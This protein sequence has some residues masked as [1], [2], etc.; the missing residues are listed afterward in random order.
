MPGREKK[1]I[2]LHLFT[3]FHPGVNSGLVS[4]VHL[5]PLTEVSNRARE[6]NWICTDS[7]AYTSPGTTVGPASPLFSARSPPMSNYAFSPS[8]GSIVGDS[9]LPALQGY[10]RN[11]SYMSGRGIEPARIQELETQLNSQKFARHELLTGSALPTMAMPELNR[12]GELSGTRL[13]RISISCEPAKS[14]DPPRTR[15]RISTTRKPNRS[16]EFTNEPPRTPVTRSRES[17]IDK[18]LPKTPPRTPP[19]VVVGSPEDVA[20]SSFRD[21]LGDT[22]VKRAKD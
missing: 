12:S 3:T 14:E 13:P 2:L 21:F 19:P 7:Q 17:S 15:P 10:V 11:S 20:D 16:E 4:R 22:G 5:S 6:I 8:N 18:E 9:H 1:G